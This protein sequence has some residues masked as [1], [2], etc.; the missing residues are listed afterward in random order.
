[1]LVEG[2]RAR[3]EVFT[4]TAEARMSKKASAID[5]VAKREIDRQKHQL[6]R[7]LDRELEDTFPASDAPKIT[8]SPHHVSPAKKRLYR[9]VTIDKQK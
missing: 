3:K 7:L 1:M 8:R 6:D 5:E 4:T 9:W 2:Q